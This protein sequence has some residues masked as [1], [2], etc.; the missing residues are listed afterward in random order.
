MEE[1]IAE[2]MNLEE[3]K[4][5]YY[6]KNKNWNWDLFK[7]RCCN[8]N[9]EKVEFNSTMSVGS[10]YY[11]EIEKEGKIIIKCHICGTAWTIDCYNFLD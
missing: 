11:D 2:R 5:K 3:F 6:T 9:S 7:I 1:K 4:E 10:G 8:C